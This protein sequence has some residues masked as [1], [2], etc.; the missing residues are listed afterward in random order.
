VS[1]LDEAL[2]GAVLGVTK[3]WA[4]QRKAEERNQR[5]RVRRAS[6]F[7]TRAWTLKEAAEQVM[8]EAYLK[9]SAGGRLPATARQIMYAARPHIQDKTG[10]DLRS[11][12]FTQTL[13]PDYMA[14]HQTEGW[15]VV[16]DARGHFHEPHTDKTVALG[17]TEVR[18]YLA[19]KPDTDTDVKRLKLD[20]PT[21]G[22]LNRY[23]AILFIEKEG[24]DQLLAAAKLAERFDIAIM[25]TKGMSV[26]AA[27]ELVEHL[28]RPLLVLHDFDQA[29]FSIIGTLRRSTRRYRFRSQVDVIDA[30]LRLSDIEELG[31]GAEYQRCDQSPSM[32]SQ[33][34]AT[35]ADID[36]LKSGQRVELNAMTSD[37]LVALI[38]QRL[39]EA[40]VVK[41]VPDDE[42][43]D[44][45]YRRAYKTA[46]LN[47]AI[48]EAAE[49]LASRTSEVEVPGDLEQLIRKRLDTE[50]TLPWDEVIAEM[51]EELVVE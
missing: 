6:A 43:L 47:K 31:L 5:A 28:R 49:D 25:S 9:A 27:R 24:F 39:D 36:F 50:Q 13:L 41:V 40:G 12:Y 46:L 19:A 20:Y 22:P 30:G 18:N 32:L 21:N 7:R 4:K 3:K 51:V 10:K 33:N 42:T 11:E 26:T 17:T 34:G 45:A 35:A 37:Q 23:D 8:E 38:E 29:G 14:S 44:A 15:N 1:G 48:D 2:S 16:Y